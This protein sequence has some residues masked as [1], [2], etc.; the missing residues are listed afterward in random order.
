[1][2]E[3]NKL[4]IF[5]GLETVRSQHEQKPRPAAKERDG[6]FSLELQKPASTKPAGPE[7]KR[8]SGDRPCELCQNLSYK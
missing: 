5:Q 7:Q 8:L 2:I 3:L 6:V 1:M 4:R